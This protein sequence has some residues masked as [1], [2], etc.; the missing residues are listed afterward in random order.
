VFWRELK[1]VDHKPN[2]VAIENLFINEN[3]NSGNTI[4]D[5]WYSGKQT[6]PFRDPK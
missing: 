5:F 3:E 4:C 2:K 6:I 1:L